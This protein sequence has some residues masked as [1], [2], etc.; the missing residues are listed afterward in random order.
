V[1]KVAW[2]RGSNST[3]VNDPFWELGRTPLNVDV[4]FAWGSVD[5]DHVFPMFRWRA[6]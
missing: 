5:G 2:H 6:S 4:P 1:L 3:V